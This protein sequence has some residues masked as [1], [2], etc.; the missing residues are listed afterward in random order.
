MYGQTLWLQTFSCSWNKKIVN[1][2]TRSPRTT[3]DHAHCVSSSYCI[4]KEPLPG[5]GFRQWKELHFS[6][7]DFVYTLFSWWFPFLNLP[8]PC[9]LG[10]V[11]QQWYILTPGFYLPQA[12]P[13]RSRF[14]V[15]FNDMVSFEMAPAFSSGF[16]DLSQIRF[17]YDLMFPLAF[18]FLCFNFTW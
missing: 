7:S 1:H 5:C 11:Y 14:L 16:S 3:K 9:P 15:H 2:V 13:L 17:T 10:L 8:L 4:H 12:C 18:V 6:S